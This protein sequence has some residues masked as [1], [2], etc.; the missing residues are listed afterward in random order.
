MNPVT[1]GPVHQRLSALVVVGIRTADGGDEN[2]VEAPLVEDCP[3]L[4]FVYH[5]WPHI[6]LVVTSGVM[7]APSVL[8]GKG[9]FLESA[10]P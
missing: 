10:V 8:P 4:V 6:G 9:A 3:P 2:G 1:R 7:R 5:R